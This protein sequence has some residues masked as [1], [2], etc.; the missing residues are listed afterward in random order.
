MEK[1]VVL[2]IIT[3]AQGGKRLLEN[4]VA[5][6]NED[7]GFVNYLAC[8]EEDYF[9]GDF[10][11]RGIPF[12]PFP[13]SRGLS[14]LSILRETARFVRLLKRLRPGVIHAHTSKA[15][16]VARLGAALYNRGKRGEKRVYVSYQVHSFYYN[17]LGGFKRK[18]FLRF[19]VFLARLSDS[20]LFQN[21][22]E[23]DQGKQ[24]RM[25]KRALLVYIGNGINLG[26]FPGRRARAMP[27]WKEGERPFTLVCVARVEPKKNHR[28]LIDAMALLREKI[29][30]TYG[31][32]RGD[33]AFRLLCV[34]EIGETW[35]PPYAE[36]RGLGK[37]ITFTGVRDRAQVAALLGESDLSVLSSTAEGK[38]RALMESMNM[39]LP[40]V[41]T[42]VV[43]TLDVVDHGVTGLLVPSGDAE[44]F[45]AAVLR[46]MED[47]LLYRSCSEKSMEKAAEEFDEEGVIKKLKTLYREKPRR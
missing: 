10:G 44:A 42:A 5:R 32:D 3:T 35:V 41:A 1:I 29:A 13:M 17:T 47:P 20:L 15:G 4:R 37:L 16:A 6:I 34:G 2:D 38:P 33:R 9:T 31:A 18:L 11:R 21:H 36:E 28:M 30:G 46:L 14:P 27:P 26:E 24:Y 8:P 45:A 25:D 40:C 7:P 12:E 39:G 43:G 19:E 23:L 22:H